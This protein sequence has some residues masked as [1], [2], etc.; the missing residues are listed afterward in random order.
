MAQKLFTGSVVT[1]AS[2]GTAEQVSSIETAITTLIV[3][4]DSTN[5]GTIYI[6]DSSVDSTNGIE[7]QPG[8]IVPISADPRSK[9]GEEVFLSD[10]Y[11]DAATNGDKARISYIKRRA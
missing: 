3:N 5:A 4:A 6:G 8:D 7:V 9:Y 11:I 1:V 10:F 2:A